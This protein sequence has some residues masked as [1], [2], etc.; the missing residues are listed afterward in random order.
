MPT[1]AVAQAYAEWL[2][3]PP[4][5]GM[6]VET[7]E[8]VGSALG[9]PVRICNRRD[10][11]LVAADENGVPRTYLPLAFTF[12]KPAIR[13][14]SE[15]VS[16][17]R[18]DALDGTLLRLLSSVR[19]IELTQP[20]YATLR[21]YVDPTILDRPAWFS[22][23]RFRAE[24][25]K[26]SLDVIEIDLVGGRMPTKRAGLYYVLERFEGLRPF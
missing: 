4:T 3:T 22:P 20:V 8:L 1:N 13:N 5:T 12:S 19:S 2:A 11:P 26:V 10:T 23:L 6:L 21:I 25:I 24:N 7:L 16:T 9:S 18:I 14:S 17:V 15:Y